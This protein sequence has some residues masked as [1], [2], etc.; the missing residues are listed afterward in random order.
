MPQRFVALLFDD[1]HLSMEDATFVRDA[2][3][4]LVRALLRLPI[5]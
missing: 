2:G 1:A 3:K 5:V 4:R